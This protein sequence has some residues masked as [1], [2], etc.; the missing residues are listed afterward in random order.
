MDHKRVVANAEPMMADFPGNH[1]VPGLE[2]PAQVAA[3]RRDGRLPVE[4]LRDDRPSITTLCPH[5]GR[6]E[7]GI[8]RKVAAGSIEGRR[9]APV[10]VME[11]SYHHS[12][13]VPRLNC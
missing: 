8:R 2:G 4:I 7:M 11:C 9:I 6:V 1:S 5:P 3:G 13:E 12:V 10:A